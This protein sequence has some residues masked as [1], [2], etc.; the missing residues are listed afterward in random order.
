MPLRQLE[1]HLHPIQKQD[2]LLRLLGKK[3]G[4]VDDAAKARIK[5]SRDRDRLDRAIDRLLDTESVDDVL[6]ALD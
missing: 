2:V 5:D 3:F 6:Q 4:A 1:L